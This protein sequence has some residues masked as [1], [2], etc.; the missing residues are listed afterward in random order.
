[1]HN[2]GYR[3][4]PAPKGNYVNV[5]STSSGN[6]AIQVGFPGFS[7]QINPKALKEILKATKLTAK[8]GVDSQVL[9]KGADAFVDLIQRYGG[10]LRLLKDR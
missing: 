1:M 5:I 6:R 2:F 9:F 7:K 4:V 3:L 8:Q 10:P